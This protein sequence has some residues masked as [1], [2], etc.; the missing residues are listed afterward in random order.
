MK[1]IRADVVI[2]GSGPAGVAVAERLHE[3][4]PSKK[5]VLLERGSLLLDRHFYNSGETIQA[6]DKFLLQHLECPWLGDL[7]DGGA[8]VPAVGGRGIVG[9]A[10]LHRFYADD[11]SVWP[12]GEWPIGVEELG[13]YFALAEER[14]LGFTKCD[15][16]A[17]SVALAQLL[18][19]G[20]EHPPFAHTAR[21]RNAEVSQG[22]P[23]RSSV[24]RLLAA[25]SKDRETGLQLIT[26][27]R[28]VS[29]RLS[30]TEPSQVSA[31]SCF[32]ASDQ[33]VSQLRVEADTF[34][35]AASPVEST[36]IVLLSDVKGAAPSL[37]RYL[38]EHMYVRG[39]LDISDNPKLAGPINLFIPP[40]SDALT[41][42]FQIELRSLGT[43]RNGQVLMRIT[44][45]AAMDP[46]RDNRVQIQ[47]DRRDGYGVP[48]ATTR[49]IRSLGDQRRLASMHESME[50]AAGYLGGHWVTP[51]E[52]L[53]RGASYHEGGCMRIGLPGTDSAADVNGRLTG[54]A[55][56]FVAD[57]AAFPTI[58]VANPILTLT[59]MGYRL[60]DYLTQDGH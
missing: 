24:E 49:L 44:G 15:G 13:P 42:R 9:G 10:Q 55:N 50:R 37:G 59:A 41:A 60:A 53:P 47:A 31:V 39:V 19:M 23:H 33:G 5:T 26:A 11:L 51:P 58:G 6:R 48:R 3:R 17:Q 16:E 18:S 54:T 38:A 30:V 46:N 29:L 4:S 2:V 35:L 25:T 34:V 22:F 20:A 21:T 52:I 32:I 57:A 40:T 43:N 12:G 8:L 7:S 36:R 45:S 14:I 56:V 1:T 28:A 27:T